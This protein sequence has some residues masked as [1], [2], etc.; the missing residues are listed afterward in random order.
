MSK[1]ST[2]FAF[3][4]GLTIGA[5]G[6]WY[7]LKD[8]YAKLAEEEIASVKAAYAKREKPTT[9]EKAGHFPKKR[10]DQSQNCADRLLANI[11][12]SE[13]TLEAVSLV[14]AAKNMDKDSITEY[15]QRLQ[16]AGY[17]DYSRTIEK[18]SGTPGEVPYVISPDEF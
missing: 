9:E 6:A 17:K 16:E 12:N 2:G 7:Y 13:Q 8:K 10:T 1:A 5:A 15:T 11:K 14:N 3:V 18:P 4:A